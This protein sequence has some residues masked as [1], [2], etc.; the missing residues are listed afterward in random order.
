MEKGQSVK[1]RLKQLR[2]ILQSGH[3]APENVDYVKGLVA[4]T[5]CSLGL[6]SL[7]L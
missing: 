5:E 4:E 1:D 6:P 7:W 2:A 3:V